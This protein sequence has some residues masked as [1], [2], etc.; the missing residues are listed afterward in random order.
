[1][2]TPIERQAYRTAQEILHLLSLTS[3]AYSQVTRNALWAAYGV[4]M[5]L[6]KEDL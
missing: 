3:D 2:S 6:S 1:M 4:T 5:D